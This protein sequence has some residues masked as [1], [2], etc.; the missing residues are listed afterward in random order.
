MKTL[1]AAAVAAALIAGPAFAQST[2]NTPST[3]P[4]AQ[5]ASPS[6]SDASSP[7]GAANGAGMAAKPMMKKH[8]AVRHVS[9]RKPMKKHMAKKAMSPAATPAHNTTN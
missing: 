4:N 5:D 7:V 2:T 3:D 9:A 1:L 8:R 6:T